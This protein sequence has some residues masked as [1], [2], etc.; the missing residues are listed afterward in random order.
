MNRSPLHG[1]HEALNARMLPFAGW[2]MPIQ[3]EGIVAEHRAVRNG[4]GVFDISHMGE[5]LVSGA[6]A[7][8]ALNGLL[9]NDVSA[10]S[11]SEGQYTLMLSE[12]GGVID[13]LIIYRSGE[14]SY[15][16][17]VNASKVEEDVKWLRSHLT[18]GVSLDDRSESLGAVAVQGPESVALWATLEPGCPLP[19]RN[20]IAE[21]E[22]GLI[23]CRTGYT[24]EDGFELFAPT[25]L[26]NGYF[27]RILDAGAAPCGLGARD[28]LR[29]EKGYPLNGS[30][31]DKD[32]TPL[33]AG[34]GFF[35]K[36]GKAE[37]FTG[38][39]ALLEQKAA[40]IDRKLVGIAMTGK[41]PPP[42]HGYEVRDEEGEAVLGELTS[43]SLSPG[44]GLGIGL[45]YLPVAN[46]VPGTEVTIMVRD[47]PFPA[48]VVKKPFL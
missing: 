21:Y 31:L 47:R 14:S 13:D 41:A 6:D 44:L 7:G 5:L 15:F 40:G 10:L 11:V 27:Q 38:S 34:L 35:V 29:L 8:R 46:A 30:D 1:I 9:T 2:E 23:L 33:E 42:R 22:G 32:H 39:A 25:E 16:L 17:V 18:E 43:G 28:T 12:E 3:Y 19:P 26:I 20:G 4:A 37:G 45:A 48:R 36:L 24:G